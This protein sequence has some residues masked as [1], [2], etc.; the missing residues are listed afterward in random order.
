MD[1]FITAHFVK[2][3]Y[4]ISLINLKWT[5]HSSIVGEG[6]ECFSLAGSSNFHGRSHCM[7]ITYI[8]GILLHVCEVVLIGL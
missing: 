4:L 8:I 7:Y 2:E 3:L 6:D 1:T 5:L